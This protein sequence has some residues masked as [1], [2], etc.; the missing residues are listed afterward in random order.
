MIEKPFIELFP[1]PLPR[2]HDTLFRQWTE[3]H[4]DAGDVRAEDLE[5]VSTTN[6]ILEAQGADLNRI[7]EQFGRIGKRQGRGDEQYRSFL[8]SIVPSFQGRGTPSGLSFAVGAGVQARADEIEIVEHFDDLEYSL[9]IHDW[10]AHEPSTVE[11]LADLADPSGVKLRTP[12][13][14]QYDTASFGLE[15]G[16]FAR[17]AA[18]TSPTG[19]YGID[20]GDTEVI[21]QGEGYGAGYFDGQDP[22]GDG[23]L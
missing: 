22:F 14:Y 16:S 19:K 7:G 6:R 10:I 2:D 5:R 3:A 9:V 11:D 17:E 18:I 1:K 21:V 15:L 4:Q 8:L 12:V 20:A 13:K 23:H